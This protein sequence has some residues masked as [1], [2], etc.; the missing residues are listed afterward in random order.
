MTARARRAPARAGGRQGAERA[1]PHRVPAER[2]WVGALLV[3]H[4]ALALWGV[5]ANSVT[6]DE[7]FHLPAGVM[8]LTRGD[9][10][11]S[12]AQPPLLKSL[13][14]LAALGAGARTPVL[15][16][17]PPNS[18]R[19]V[20]EA[21]MRLNAAHYIRVFTAARLPVVALSLLLAL[22]VWRFARRL[23]G[24]RG[25]LVALGLYAFAPE[26]LAHAGVVGMD[27]AT[28]LGFTASLYAFW[29]FARDGSW[30][31]LLLTALAVG[32]SLLTRFSALQLAPIL[33]AL[34][35]VG[36]LTGRLRRP[37]RVWLGLALMP[38]VALL[39]LQLAYRGQCSFAPL[40]RW[41]FLS[42]G[43]Q[44]LR[45]QFPWLRLPLPD[46]A[47]A[48][49][50]Y[51][52]MLSKPGG[53][54]TY[55]LGRGVPHTYWYYFPLALLFKWPLGFLGALAARAGLAL[56]VPAGPRRRWNEAFLLIPVAVLLF[57]AMFL[58]RLDVG[59]R[60]LLP[61]L[62]LLCVWC[63][64]LALPAARAAVARQR[65][66]ARWALAGWLLV[67]AGAVETAFAAPR[68]LS[69][70]NR[71]A[72]GPGGGD[73]LIN[74]SNVDWGQGLIALRHEM[75]TLGIRRILL[76]YHGTTDPRAAA[77]VKSGGLQQAF[78][79]REL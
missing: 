32:L 57:V 39:L 37:G 45:E 53:T 24:P 30:R 38:L 77:I 48:G 33:I 12:L 66:L 71:F 34:A 10:S 51:L 11:V 27:L 47:I 23:Y 7:N 73:R 70:F 64:G 62:P 35:L 68:Y 28:A 22:L 58:T 60:Y 54:T 76:A 13:C 44:H 78:A 69:F 42:P 75:K 29:R 6:F 74:D 65:E 3:A 49:L 40:A 14:A 61:I 55:L 46:A 63:G 31:W 67:G 5:A 43:F 15:P 36:T 21:F 79:L 2:A 50:D 19:A 9:Y 72:G 59:I 16:A 56:R 8:I 4:L 17:L 18:E 1:F 20:G 26:A 41:S 52:A 25:A